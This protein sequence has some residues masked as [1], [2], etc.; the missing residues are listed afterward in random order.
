[1]T[2]PIQWEDGRAV[3]EPKKPGKASLGCHSEERERNTEGIRTN[4]G[5]SI[6][7]FASCPVF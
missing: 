7:Q 2:L 6:S 4:H 1:M 3:N 5:K